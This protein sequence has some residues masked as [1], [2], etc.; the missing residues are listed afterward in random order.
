MKHEQHSAGMGEVGP[1]LR[2]V[3]KL[4]QAVKLEQAYKEEGNGARSR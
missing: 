4:T 3:G 1:V 2:A